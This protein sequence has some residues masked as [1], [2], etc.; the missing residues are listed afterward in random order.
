MIRV[1]PGVVVEAEILARIC[2]AGIARLYSL[3]DKKT[4]LEEKQQ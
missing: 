4:R 3:I 1:G 2:G